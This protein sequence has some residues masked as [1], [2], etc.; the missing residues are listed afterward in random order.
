[1]TQDLAALVAQATPGPWAVEGARHS[2]D[3]KIGPNTRLHFVGPDGDAVAAVFFDMKTGQGLPDARLIA[4]APDLARTVLE[5]QDTLEAQAAEIARLTTD[6]RHVITERDETFALMLARAEKAEAALSE[7]QAREATLHR[8]LPAASQ[9]E[10][11]PVAWLWR[12][13][14]GHIRCALPNA[15]SSVELACA[16]HDGDEIVPLYAHPTPAPVVPAE[17]LE[18]SRE[19]EAKA[20][21]VLDMELLK[22]LRSDAGDWGCSLD[23]EAVEAIALEVEKRLRAQQPA[24]PVSGVTVQEA[25]RVPEISAFVEA[26]KHFHSACQSAWACGEPSHKVERMLDAADRF[27]AAISALEGK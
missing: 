9:P 10:A 16:H 26:G 13:K 27:S 25:A 3:L 19:D 11:E 20:G 2:G 22:E 23:L 14:D 1:M 15:P 6:L 21:W 17:G 12:S 24:A 4:M 18:R 7:S 5:Q 8:A